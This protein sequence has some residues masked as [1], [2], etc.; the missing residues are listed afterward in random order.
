M[1]ENMIEEMTNRMKPVMDLAETNK[2]VLETLASVQKDT[3]TD[4]V[5]ASMEQFQALSQCKDPKAALE[6]QVQFYK[7]LEAKMTNTTEQSI[8]AFSEVKNAYTSVLEES[9]KTA[10]AEVEKVVKQATAKTA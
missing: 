9:A 8:A 7:A 3:L 1:Y 10:T 6:L 4:V 2:K 5:N